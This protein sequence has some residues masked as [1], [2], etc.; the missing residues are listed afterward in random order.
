MNVER[1]L[2]IAVGMDPH[3][4]DVST[5]REVMC[6]RAMIMLGIVCHLMIMPLVKVCVSYSALKYLMV[7]NS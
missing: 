3:Q 4:Q 6:A 7:Y 1:I 5:L 2:T